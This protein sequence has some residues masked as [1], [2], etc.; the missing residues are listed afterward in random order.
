LPAEQQLQAPGSP[1]H[2]DPA[3]L[4]TSRDFA[5]R[6]RRYAIAAL[7]TG[8]ILGLALL[9]SGIKAG[10]DNEIHRTLR[11]FGADSWL[12]SRGSSGPFTAPAVFPA[13]SVDQVRALP[14][15]RLADPVVLVVATASTPGL[16]DVNLIGVVPRGVG[17]PRGRD[18]RLLT[19]GLAIVDS[20]LG[21]GVG[22][23]LRLNGVTFRIG[24]L[25]R[26]LTY[27]GGTPT[28]RVE[29]ARAQQLA[30]NGQPLASA[31][32]VRGAPRPAASGFDALSNA[33]VASDLARPV[34][35]AKKTISLI[36]SLLWL[37]AACI[38]GAVLYLTTLDRVGDF[39][40]MKAIGVSTRSLL[41]GLVAQAAALSAASALLA[42]G[43]VAAVGSDAG[44][45]V[46]VPLSSY[47]TL[48]LVAM[49]VATVG[50]LLALRRAVT[51][52]PARAFASRA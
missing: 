46:E 35:Q 30:F 10:F 16:S 28:V 39:A 7:A 20:S 50:S 26:G 33:Q 8:L 12:V 47:V 36:R 15:V 48:V 43:F 25:T 40:V 31:I 44:V 6:K 17:S 4:L 3:W 49:L 27:F 1:R 2:L 14:G 38:I 22:A 51:V 37:V 41:A 21:L 19:Q 34:A 52:D 24:A 11:S 32:V 5:W 13:A 18:A 42:A 23:Q 29:L 9:L 45:P